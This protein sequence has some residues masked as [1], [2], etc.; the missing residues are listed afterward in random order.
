MLDDLNKILDYSI[1][2]KYLLLFIFVIGCLLVIVFMS[3]CGGIA[4]SLETLKKM[5]ECLQQIHAH[6]A[7]AGIQAPIA[8]AGIQAPIASANKK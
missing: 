6:L 5:I 4:N 2:I 3:V 7:P 8:P 1:Q